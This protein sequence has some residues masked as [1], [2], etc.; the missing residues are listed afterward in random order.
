MKV[1]ALIEIKNLKTH[2]YTQKGI[3]KAVDGI[4]FEVYAGETVGVV[5]ESGCGKSV[6]ALTILQLIESPPGKIADG[7][8][9]FQGKDIVALSEDEMKKIRGKEIS[10]IFQEPMTSLNP[11]FTIGDQIAEAIMEHKQ[12]S[13]KKA[14]E[15]TVEML[16]QVEIPLPEK[17]IYEYPH[18]L[19]GGMQQR[20]MIAMALSCEPK[21]LIADEPTTALDVTVQARILELMENLKKKLNTS[22]LMITHDLGVI[23]EICDRVAVM[24]AGRIVE[25]TDVKTLFLRPRHPYTW[26]L[27]NSV[28]K[29]DEDTER[30]NTIKGV[31]PNPLHFP[32]GCKFN[33]RCIFADEKCKEQEPALEEIEPGHQVRCWHYKKLEEYIQRTGSQAK[34]AEA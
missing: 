26:G 32:P 14:F 19:S 16:R 22:V 20:V 11:V 29:I 30:L 4:S 2:F 31:V 7:S 12:V 15:Q 28:P 34:T 24:Y 17:R 9:L 33:N 6:T 8:I 18:Q 3:V 5:G 23:A 27:M 25:Y 10:M 1:D 21:L 13:K